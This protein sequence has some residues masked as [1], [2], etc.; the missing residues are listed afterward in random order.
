MKSLQFNSYAKQIDG[1]QYCSEVET[2]AENMIEGNAE[3]AGM[4]FPGDGNWITVRSE[5]YRKSDDALIV[6]LPLPIYKLISVKLIPKST[7]IFVYSDFQESRLE[8]NWEEFK[9]SNGEYFI[10]DITRYFLTQAEHSAL[11]TAKQFTDIYLNPLKNYKQNTF[12][13]TQGNRS[14]K[15]GATS[16]KDITG[17]TLPVYQVVLRLLPRIAPLEY[18]A[19][20][21]N[22][23]LYLSLGDVYGNNVLDWEL[24]IKY[25]PIPQSTKMK[26]HKAEKKPRKYAQIVNQ[27]AEVNNAEAFGKYLHTTAQKTGTEKIAIAKTYTKIADVPPVGAVVWHNGEKYRLVANS[28]SVTN[29]VTFT[30]THTL[31]K[32]WSSKSKHVAVDQKY[33][34]WNIPFDDYVWRTV[35]YEE[36]I[37]FGG[38]P[39][40]FDSVFHVDFW[41]NSIKSIFL[42]DAT[43][44]VLQNMWL[45]NLDNNRNSGCVL[46]VSTQGIGKSLVF[47]A[48]TKDTLSVGLRVNPD[49]NEYCEEVLYCNADG[50]LKEM[51]IILSP[52]I[53]GYD[54]NA[55]PYA[56]LY[57]TNRPIFYNNQRHFVEKFWLDKDPGEAIKVTVQVHFIPTENWIVVGN[58]FAQDHPFVSGKAKEGLKLWILSEYIRDGVDFILHGDQDYVVGLNSNDEINSYLLCNGTSILVLDNAFK[59]AESESGRKYKAWAITDKDNNLYIGSNDIEKREIFI[60]IRRNRT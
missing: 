29:T 51:S 36:F 60:N 15:I 48:S 54:K 49:D 35:Y 14:L 43:N 17:L 32:N 55:Y 22:E 1:E 2:L 20:V 41:K 50:T 58:K 12:I 6:E 26:A 46:P 38:T 45:I 24:Q 13:Y 25:I 18:T 4:E 7:K 8:L 57:T 52:E 23:E 5:L 19:K 30:V 44:I 59:S 16:Y 3:D 37:E 27:R 53:E 33:R 56:T 39:V 28:W 31:S 10:P 34:N 40:T 47:S 21:E 11:P 9:N 42:L